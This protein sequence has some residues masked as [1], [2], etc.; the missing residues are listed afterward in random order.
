MEKNSNN[1][2]KKNELSCR[3]NLCTQFKLEIKPKKH[4]AEIDHFKD[5]FST[6]SKLIFAS[7]VCTWYV[8]PERNTVVRS[9]VLGVI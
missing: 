6:P 9:C 3:M 8:I 7:L 4:E 5:A 1:N 2:T